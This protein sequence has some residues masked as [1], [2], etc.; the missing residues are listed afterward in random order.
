MELFNLPFEEL[1]ELRNRID[2]MIR[3]YK[4]G[5]LYI[6]KVR[7]YGRNWTENVNNLRLNWKSCVTVMMVKMVLLM[8]ILPT[9]T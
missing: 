9:P 5:Y 1:I 3:S 6:C 4:D 8:F 7:S 2:G